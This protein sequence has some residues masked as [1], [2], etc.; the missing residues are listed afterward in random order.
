MP[1]PKLP[2][3]TLFSF[4]KSLHKR[5]HV[6]INASV[7]FQHVNVA[8]GSFSQSS[9]TPP[10]QMRRRYPGT[11]GHRSQLHP[12]TSPDGLGCS[13][14]RRRSGFLQARRRFHQTC[15]RSGINVVRLFSSSLTAMPSVSP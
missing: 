12:E 9:G 4:P 11:S 3:F 5:G 7:L 8:S 1:T 2:G 10:G 13:P 14:R 15:C 6:S